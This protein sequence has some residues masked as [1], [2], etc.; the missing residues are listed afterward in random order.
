MYLHP[1]V[2]NFTPIFVLKKVL[3]AR[4]YTCFIVKVGLQI[5][6]SHLFY[7]KSGVTNTHITPV[8]KKKT[9]IIC[10]YYTQ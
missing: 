4:F 2:Q 9:G 7:C 5:H 10:S 3:Y 6:I 1:T 8:Y